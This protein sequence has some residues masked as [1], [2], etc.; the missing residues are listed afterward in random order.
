[1]TKIDSKNI[2]TEKCFKDLTAPSLAKKDLESLPI[3]VAY[4]PPADTA[5]TRVTKIKHLLEEVLQTL[6]PVV[7]NK[8]DG[9]DSYTNQQLIF[10]ENVAGTCMNWKNELASYK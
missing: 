1:M 7:M 9:V 2:K 10:L 3:P 5:T 8:I 4:K 6:V